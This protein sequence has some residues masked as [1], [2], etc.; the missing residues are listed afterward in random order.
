MKQ[1][2]PL[3]LWL[4]AMILIAL[5]SG[6][7]SIS[8]AQ[9]DGALSSWPTV[10]ATNPADGA[11]VV[12]LNQAITVTFSAQISPA[13]IGPT[14]VLR[15]A[16]GSSVDGNI[17]FH[18]TT[19]V[20]KPV[21]PLMPD[22][23]YTAE[24]GAP[25]SDQADAVNER[26]F[27]WTFTTGT[28]IDATNPTVTTTIPANTAVGVPTNQRIDAMFSE[29]MAP[30]SL[31]G[32]TFR[33][34]KPG[35]AAIAGAITYVSGSAVF[36]PLYRLRTNT[37]YIATITTGAKDLA[38]N[39][40]AGNYVWSF[41]TGGNPEL[42]KP[43]VIS[44]NPAS[45]AMAVPIDQKVSATFSKPMN[46]RTITTADFHLT[47]SG[48]RVL[49]TIKY[50]Y[51]ATDKVT[52]A[53]F[54]PKANLRVNTQYTATITSAV[55]DLTGNQL[56]GN[57]RSG[58]YVWQFT[59]GTAAGLGTV[60][61]GAA[62][63]FAVLAAAAVTNTSTPTMITGDLGLWPGT[64]VTNFPPGMVNGSIDINDP[65]AQAGEAALA[66]AYNDA[67]GRSGAFTPA[68][69]NVGG[70]TFTP[71]LYRSG[72]STEIS[73]G[74]D[75]TLDAQGD[76]TAVFIFQ[77]ASTLTTSSG[78]GITLKG[79]AQASQIFWQVGSSATIGTG[80]HFAGNILANTSITLVSGAVLDGRALAGAADLTGAVTMDDNTIV[81][82]S[83]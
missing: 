8:S 34:T 48:G 49:G 27:A 67:A 35:G 29:D 62:A 74:G 77:I 80:S 70:L 72:S 78:F 13:S 2:V 23:T 33:I 46:Y 20:F 17:N 82:P 6:T 66:I 24:I 73:G 7:R 52:I 83:P 76:P 56:A 12:N 3:K 45:N 14:V 30:A 11:T 51:D 32:K 25:A 26:G 19:V 16:D 53:T 22:T 63:N 61:L 65:A 9:S 43:V 40:L 79:G 54:V 81:R 1:P 71:G 28:T 55:R 10:T 69:G 36:R 75:L 4:I 5:I 42:I 18:G 59:T 38:G 41:D 58:N 39:P 57:K 47:W 44:T 21:A 60:A 68:V 31:R 15:A 37:H 64:S 50:F